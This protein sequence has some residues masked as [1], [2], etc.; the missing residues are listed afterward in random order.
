MTMTWFAYV[1]D[2][3]VE[4]NDSMTRVQDILKYHFR[5]NHIKLKAYL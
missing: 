4:V 1:H 5:E 2:R 3:C